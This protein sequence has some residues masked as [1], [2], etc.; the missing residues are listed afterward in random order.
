MTTTDIPAMLLI[1]CFGILV[2]ALAQL[3][4][5]QKEAIGHA[6]GIS[7][8][9]AERIYRE[10][11]TDGDGVTFRWREM[12]AYCRSTGN[13]ARFRFW[14]GMAL[15]AVAGGIGSILLDQALR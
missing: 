5:I 7:P 15:T 13:A 9:E 12:H 8:A 1:A 2:L 6:R 14:I 3:A 4:R 10:D 11:Y